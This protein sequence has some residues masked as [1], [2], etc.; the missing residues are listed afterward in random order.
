MG[1]YSTASEKIRPKLINL[2]YVIAENGE[3]WERT[4]KM[5]F[6]RAD[7]HAIDVLKIAGIDYDSLANNHSLDFGECRKK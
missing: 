4:H 3:S 6:F 7:P 5:F 2:E 1:R